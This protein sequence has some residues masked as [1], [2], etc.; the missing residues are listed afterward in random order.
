MKFYELL[1]QVIKK[2]MLY[3]GESNLLYIKIFL[4]GYIT[5]A[6]ENGDN[7][8]ALFM[9]NFQKY[10]QKKF[11]ESKTYGWWRIIEMNCDSSQNPLEMFSE[12]VYDFK[13]QE[14]GS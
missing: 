12:L 13:K 2:P 5:C 1:S 11:R 8:P 14:A 3:V 9:S 6:S 7:I 10:V 4:D